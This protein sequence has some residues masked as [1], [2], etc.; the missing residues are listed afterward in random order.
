M[1]DFNQLHHP[2]LEEDHEDAGALHSACLLQLDCSFQP[3]CCHASEPAESQASTLPQPQLLF[4]WGFEAS[5]P[6]QL[7]PPAPFPDVTRSGAATVEEAAEGGA[8]APAA[9]A[10]PLLLLTAG[11][12]GTGMW[13]CTERRS[14]ASLRRL[15]RSSSALR[16]LSISEFSAAVVFFPEDLCSLSLAACEE[17]PRKKPASALSSSPPLKPRM[18]SLLNSSTTIFR[19]GMS[20]CLD[21]A[22]LL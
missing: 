21:F 12:L 13:G 16:S 17:V 18:S 10:R 11:G 3:C 14:V 15:A 1:P 19:S 9:S 22:Y 2:F 5:L 7:L 6:C 4:T 20:I 8:A